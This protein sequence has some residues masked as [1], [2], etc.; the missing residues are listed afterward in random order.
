MCVPVRRFKFDKLAAGTPKGECPAQSLLSPGARSP[1][2]VSTDLGLA[3]TA[4]VGSTF[5]RKES[6]AGGLACRGVIVV[7]VGSAPAWQETLTGSSRRHC[8]LR[9]QLCQPAPWSETDE[10]AARS[11]G[12]PGGGPQGKHR[13]LSVFCTL[14]FEG[15]PSSPPSPAHE[16]SGERAWTA[17]GQGPLRGRAGNGGRQNSVSGCRSHTRAVPQ[18]ARA[19]PSVLSHSEAVGAHAWR[20]LSAVC[21]RGACGAGGPVDGAKRAHPCVGPSTKEK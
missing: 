4:A 2:V 17:C 20:R 8:H 10:A 18:A 21:C 12:N 14:V 11:L 1:R 19:A 6:P 3:A 7:R 5:L 15:I 16:E 13:V 9:P